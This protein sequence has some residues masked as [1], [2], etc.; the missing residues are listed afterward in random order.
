[1]TGAASGI[2]RAIAQ[3]LVARGYR[4]FGTSR[5]PEAR[6]GSPELPLLQLDVRSDDSV[7]AAL[8]EVRS[9]AGRLDVLVNN[10]AYRLLGAAEETSVEEARALFD[11]NFFGMHRVTRA[12]LPAL[13]AAGR[14]RIV[15]IS[16]LAGLNSPPFAALYSAS[17]SAVEAYTESLRH[18][19]RP[20]GI[21]VSLIEPG[22]V[23]SEGREAPQ[24]PREPL[25]DYDGPRQRAVGVI[26]G[27]DQTGVDAARVAQMVTRVVASPSP[28]LRYRVGPDATWLPRLKGALPWSWY[29]EAVRRRYR[30]DAK[31]G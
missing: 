29:E 25:A 26:T 8:D 7:R 3:A 2:G 21:Q 30:L 20:L 24:L 6:S 16:S 28:G 9:R 23:R 13:R 18:E 31:G 15:N 10:A 11:T 17:K 22:A 4:V 14:G 1:V 19:L 12:A 5:R 27:L